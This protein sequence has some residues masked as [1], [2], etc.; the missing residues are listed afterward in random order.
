MSYYNKWNYSSPTSTAEVW[1]SSVRNGASVTINAQV[2]CTFRY[3]N[4]YIEYNGEI[5]FNMWVANASAS[6]NIKGYYDRW[7]GSNEMSRTR[8]CSMTFNSLDSGISLGFNINTPTGR[9][10]FKV[11]D[12]YIT[13]DLPTY[14]PPSAPTWI[15]INPN[16]CNVTSA[17]LISWGGAVPG[18]L[19]SL[20]YDLQTRALQSNGNW[21]DWITRGT[22]SATSFS[23]QR[24]NT[25]TTAGFIPYIGIQY[26]Y[27]VRSSDGVYA[28]SGW[29]TSGV[30]NITFGNPNP[31]TSYSVSPDKVKK[32][33]TINTSW[34]GGDGGTGNVTS[35]SLEYRTYIKD[36][37]SWSEWKV[38][39]N[40]SSTSYLFNVPAFFPDAKNGDMIEFRVRLLNS[41]G[42]YSTYLNMSSVTIKGNRIW[43][44]INGSWVEGESYLKVNNSWVEAT[45]YI[46]IN[47]SWKEAN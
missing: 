27:R 14:N 11:P 12:T 2:T 39:Y 47:G 41:W 26:Q 24:I 33:G 6:A 8:Y 40:G 32:E 31:P 21:T 36:T 42:Q 34:S 15:N 10:V 13:L 1:I 17:P 28:T 35:Y 23:E 4:S 46:K 43:I 9:Q 29:L 20:Y 3:T 16:P 22:Y 25:F 7:Y 19:G 44:K 37:K 45:P 38:A 18:S 5:N 30:L